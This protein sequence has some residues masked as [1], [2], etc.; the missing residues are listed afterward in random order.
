LKAWIPR[1][2]QVAIDLKI[3]GQAAGW[4]DTLRLGGGALG[5]VVEMRFSGFRVEAQNDTLRLR[6]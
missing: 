1:Q 4:N 5:W 2:P 3:T 6:C